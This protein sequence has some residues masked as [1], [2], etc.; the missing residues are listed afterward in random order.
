VLALPDVQRQYVVRHEEEHRAAHDGRVLFV[1]SLTLLLMPWN[2][3]L[4]WQLR[5]LCLAIEMD[6]DTRVVAGLGD[7]NAY[8][9]LLLKIAEA[10][11][12]GLRLQPALLGGVGTLEHRLRALLAPT[13]LRH[14]QRFVLPAFAIGLLLLVLKMPHPILGGPSE[15]HVT[16]TS[17]ATN[18]PTGAAALHSPATAQTATQR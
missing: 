1:A 2:L 14:V 18:A 8:G 4:W 15:A 5:R 3:A 10:S 13:P 7:A 12:R 11:N 9:A 6:C 17:V 16:M